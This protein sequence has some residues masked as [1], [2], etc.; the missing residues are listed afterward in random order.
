MNYIPV[1]LLKLRKHYGYSQDYLAKVL[2]IDVNEY[3][4]YENGGKVPDHDK[5]LKL[6]KI[7]HINVDEI[8]NNKDDKVTLHEI[9]KGNKDINYFSNNQDIKTRI[10]KLIRR[11]PIKSGACLFLLLL[12]II[13]CLIGIN[14]DNTYTLSFENINRLCASDTTIV[15][16]DDKKAVYGKGNNDNKQIS[17]LPSSGIIKVCESKN[18]TFVLDENGGVSFY[19]SNEELEK[20]ISKL[21]NIVDIACGDEHFVAL[22]NKGNVYALGNNDVGQC[23]V[24][25]FENITKIF[26]SKNGTILMDESGKLYS[27]GEFIGQSRLK[28]HSNILD[29][30]VDDDNLLIL[31][32]NGEVEYE[33]SNNKFVGV[34]KWKDVVDVACGNIFA[35]GLKNDGTVYIESDDE[36]IV[37]EVNKWTNI[38]AI[39]SAGDCLVGYDGNNIYAVGDNEYLVSKKDKT[40]TLPQVTNVN[41]EINETINVSFDKVQNALGYKISLIVPDVDTCTY[42]VSSNE[43][44]SF[45]TDNLVEGNEYEITISTIGDGKKYLDSAPLNVN[46]IYQ[47]NDETSEDYYVTVDV[48]LYSMNADELEAYLKSIGITNIVKTAVE[49]EDEKEGTVL[50]SVNGISSNQRYL[51][52]ELSKAMVSYN[53][54]KIKEEENKDIEGE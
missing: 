14:N 6:S 30:D 32:S 20:E 7:Y 16:I 3:M 52:S 33:S 5:C 50:P 34:Y 42:E 13:V 44:V 12:I 46:F 10:I 25:D 23:N 28:N 4:A 53:Y 19:P 8:I 15:Y 2:K 41:V 18:Y 39:S 47:K 9:K 51:K 24:E 38:I 49:C 21:K 40:V 29:I 11:Y 22:D 37:D 17:N 54:C 45:V 36:D 35:A 26:A 43:T 1:K 48:D 31:N 27:C